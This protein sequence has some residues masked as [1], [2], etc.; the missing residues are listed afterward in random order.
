MSNVLKYKTKQNKTIEFKQT[1]SYNTYH[2]LQ[3]QTLLTDLKSTI[4]R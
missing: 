1:F 4:V 3:S 2:I